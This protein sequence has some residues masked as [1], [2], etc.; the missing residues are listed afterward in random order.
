MQKNKSGH[1]TTITERPFE[2]YLNED[3]L[4]TATYIITSRTSPNIM[5]GLRTGARKILCATIEGKLKSGNEEKLMILLGETFAMN[6]H[7]GDSS[8][9]G[10]IESMGMKHKFFGAPL[11]VVGQIPTLREPEIKTAGRY[12]YVEQN[13]ENMLLFNKDSDLLVKEME[14]GHFFEPTFYLPIIPVSLLIETTSPGFGF[15]Y[16]S[17]QFKL[18]SIIDAT[19]TTLLT[20]KCTDEYHSKLTP[21]VLGIKE[22]NFI[23]NESLDSWY[24]VGEY[25]VQGNKLIITDLPWNVSDTKYEA[26]LTKLV[27]L[28]F[29][30]DYSNL[31]NNGYIHFELTFITA[32]RLQQLMKQ[33]LLFFHKLMLYKKITKSSLNLLDSDCKTLI[34]FPNENKLIEHFVKRRLPYYAK[35]KSLLLLDIKKR[36]DYLDDIVKFISLII[37]EK[38]IINKRKIADIKLDLLN[39]GVSY[40]GLDLKISRLTLE[41]INKSN[42]EID[43]LKKEQ[44]KIENTTETEM[45]VTD[46]IELKISLGEEIEELK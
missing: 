26:H 37:D 33:K 32:N 7:H 30:L 31:S 23:H 12:L 10:T 4:A 2:K 1:T 9:I 6:F 19:L 16:K 29:I 21:F 36:I 18:D 13:K 40:A 43:T 39:F 35:R 24:N 8:I 46:L 34:N 11:N 27:S 28:G 15:N 45:Y 42:K 44:K 25:E 22:E 14:E 17:N 3:L 5:D 20:K 41:E 38:L